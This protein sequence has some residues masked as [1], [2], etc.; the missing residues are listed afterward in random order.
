MYIYASVKKEDRGKRRM[1]RER[2]GNGNEG[3][4]EGKEKR[5]S[6]KRKHNFLLRRFWKK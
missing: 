3:R 4:N 5:G 6:E 1:V 2:E